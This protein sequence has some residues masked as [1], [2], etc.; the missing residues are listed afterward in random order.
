MSTTVQRVIAVVVLLVAG[1][2]SLPLAASVL[3]SG[4]TE[5][6]IIPVQVVATAIIGAGVAVL[7]P[8]IAP[9]GATTGRRVVVGAIWGVLAALFGLVVFFFLLNGLD[10]A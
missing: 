9:V 8:A 3:D 1:I 10:G 5:N 7:L 2:L 4:G 6:W